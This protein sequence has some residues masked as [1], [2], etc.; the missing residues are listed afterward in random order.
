MGERQRAPSAVRTAVVWDALR[1]ALAQRCAVSGRE[2]LDVLD[3]GGGTGGFAVPIATLGHAVTVVEPSL[4]SLAALERRAAE[5]GVTSRIRP[6]QGEAADL[7]DV[8]GDEGADLVLCHSVLEYVDDPRAAITAIGRTARV[9]GAVSVLAPNRTAT[10]LH[11]ALAG[12]FDDARHVLT[13][14]DGR[15]GDKDPLPRRFARPAIVELLEAAGLAVSAIHGV[16]VFAD[17]VPGA[18]VD[19]EPEAIDALL[20]LEAA[21]VEHAALRDVATQLHL[22]AHRSR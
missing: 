3:A 6:V 11:R 2:V 9:G 19:G 13:D 12:H 7:L 22:L 16:R 1:V 5:A 8:V 14:P 17:L 21:T 15:W 10:V 20:A 18:L 4:D